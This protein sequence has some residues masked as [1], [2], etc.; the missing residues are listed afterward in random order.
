MAQSIAKRERFIGKLWEKKID[1]IIKQ[2]SKRKPRKWYA[3]VEIVYTWPRGW[4]KTEKLRTSEAWYKKLEQLCILWVLVTMVQVTWY[5]N[6]VRIPKSR[7]YK[8]Y[9]F[10]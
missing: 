6:N 1:S 9:L 10:F 3:L 7:E 2:G 4:H 8:W 5:K